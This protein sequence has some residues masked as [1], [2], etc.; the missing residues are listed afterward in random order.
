M[1]RPKCTWQRNLRSK[2]NTASFS[3]LKVFVEPGKARIHLFKAFW[4]EE[5]KKQ[6]P[7]STQGG[8]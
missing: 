1:V 6:N 7:G 5:V 4:E 3:V 8:T 2:K